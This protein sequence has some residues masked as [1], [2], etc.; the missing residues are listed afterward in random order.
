MEFR[1]VCQ[2]KTLELIVNSQLKPDSSITHGGRPQTFL[3]E[4]LTRSASARRVYLASILLNLGCSDVALKVRVPL[5]RRDVRVDL[6]AK[7]SNLILIVAVTSE[8]RAQ[9]NSAQLKAV[10]ERM[11]AEL[12]PSDVTVRGLVAVE[13]L[14][15]RTGN[16][17]RSL[18]GWA[19]AVSIAT[20]ESWSI[21]D[22]IG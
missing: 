3:V 4:P 13:G 5:G 8:G 6:M 22:V 14:T 10:R 21:S 1:L 15:A 19:H 2:L 16:L 20:A 11:E 18:S 9:V 12:V 17:D 7:F